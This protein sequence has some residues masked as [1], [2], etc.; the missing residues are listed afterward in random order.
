MSFW[1]NGYAY[2]TISQTRG[3]GKRIVTMTALRG[4]V[5]F[6]TFT[7]RAYGRTTFALP[8]TV[9]SGKTI[10]LEIAANDSTAGLPPTT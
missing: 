5:S 8:L 4:D 6:R 10:S 2:G 3:A 1:S 9:G 7:L